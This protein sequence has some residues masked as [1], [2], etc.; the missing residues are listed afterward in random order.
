[1]LH[2]IME[3]KGLYNFTRRFTSYQILNFEKILYMLQDPKRVLYRLAKPV[4]NVMIRTNNTEDIFGADFLL[5]N[6]CVLN[7]SKYNLSPVEV[8][9]L[10]TLISE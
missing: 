3:I 1:M 9:R 10:L 7:I 8:H 5:Y 6:K 4:L 2:L